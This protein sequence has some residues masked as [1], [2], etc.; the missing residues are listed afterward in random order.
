MSDVSSLTILGRPAAQFTG[1][2][3]TTWQK[4][5]FIDFDA[6]LIGLLLL[7]SP[8]N[9]QTR[10][11]STLL[12]VGNSFTFDVSRFPQS[13]GDLPL[14]QN[15]ALSDCSIAFAYPDGWKAIQLSADGAPIFN[16]WIMSYDVPGRPSGNLPEAG[17]ARLQLQVIPPGFLRI[18]GRSSID[19]FSRQAGYRVTSRLSAFNGRATIVEVQISNG[20]KHI[21]DALQIEIVNDDWSITRLSLFCAPDELDRWRAIALAVVE[22]LQVNQPNT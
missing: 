18:D 7:S 6:D 19:Q 5:I 20:G 22:S 15:F 11:D 1:Y 12:E 14:T 17:Q 10:W 2:S 8:V 4:A 13:S 21:G 3:T 9:D 16:V